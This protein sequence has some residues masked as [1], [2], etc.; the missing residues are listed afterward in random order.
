[1]SDELTLDL[2]DEAIKRLPQ[3]KRPQ[4]MRI[5]FEDY[6][7]LRLSCDGL[8]ILPESSKGVTPGFLMEIIPAGDLSRGQYE[9]EF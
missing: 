9:I 6:Q 7:R 8:E 1:M 5:S 4:R 3:E 2:I